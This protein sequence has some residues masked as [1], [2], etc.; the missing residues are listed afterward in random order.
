MF[1]YKIVSYHIH[2]SLE[3]IKK[4]QNK[5]ANATDEIASIDACVYVIYFTFFSFCVFLCIT[6]V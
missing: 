5:E 6:L 4:A 3:N 1:D 2:S